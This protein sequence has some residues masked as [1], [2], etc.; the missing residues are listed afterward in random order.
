MRPEHLDLA[1]VAAV[2]ARA[3]A[4]ASCG[5]TRRRP[6][7]SWATPA[8]WRSA[9]GSPAWRSSTNTAAAAAHHRRPL[10]DR[11][12]LGDHPGGQLPAASATRVFR[13]APIHHHFELAG[14][15][16]DDGHRPLLDPRRPVHRARAR[17]LLRRL[18]PRRG[19][20][21]DRRRARP[22][23][24][25]LRRHRRGRR[26]GAGRS[27]AATS[28]SSTTAPRPTQPG[29]GR[30]L[31]RRA[32]STRP[33]PA[34]L[35][36]A[37]R[38]A[39]TRSLPS[40]GVPDAPPGRSPRARRAGVPVCSEF[41]LASA[42]GRPRRAS[43]SPG[44]NGKTT[45]TTLVTD[46]ARGRRA[47]APLAAGNTEVPLVEAIDEPDLDVFVVEASSFRLATPRASRRPSPPGSTS[48]RTTSTGTRPWPTTPHAKARDLADRPA[49]E[50]RRR[51]RR[52]PG[53]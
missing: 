16:R 8:R 43:P 41:D 11:D 36:G 32:A 50:R 2:D 46:D 48:P 52:R 6:G 22:A 1:L 4:P 45:V 15:A 34:A 26:P 51:Q 9:P 42:L 28:S 37:G 21:T 39:P 35:D 18:P 14:L 5:G 44:P 12:G 53:R 27:A 17:H 7:S 13:M 19:D 23:R 40:P 10:R 29:R 31:R 47:G 24:R 30:R 3:P 33:T 25:R 38:R 49:G 20:S